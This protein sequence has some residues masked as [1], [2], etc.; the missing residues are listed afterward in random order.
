MPGGGRHP[1]KKS[2]AASSG[3]T[4]VHAA[5]EPNVVYRRPSALRRVLLKDDASLPSA[6]LDATQQLA[7]SLL[8]AKPVVWRGTGDLWQMPGL[9]SQAFRGR[10]LLI[11]FWAGV[12]GL[13][14]ALLSLGINFIGVSAEPSSD[15]VACSKKCM[16]NLVHV[17]RV[18]QL[19]PSMFRSLLNSKTFE[20]VILG[21]GSPCQG[22]S[23]LN[24]GRLGLQDPRSCQPKIL[25]DFADKMETDLG[26]EV[27][28][29]LE[30]AGSVPDKVAKQYS[31]W[32]RCP[33]LMSQ[34]GR[35]GWVTRKRKYWLRGPSGDLFSKLVKLPDAWEILEDLDD[36][37]E[38]A[39]CGSKPLPP[40]V[41]FTGGYAPLFDPCE[42][43]K[44]KGKGA[45][46]PF[47]REFRHPGDNKQGVSP[48]ACGRYE[49]D[50]RRF[51][52]ASYELESLLWYGN[53]WRQPDPT[54][55][56]IIHGLPPSIVSAISSSNSAK[57]IQTQNSLVGNGFHMPTVVV[58]IFC[59]LQLG[60]S[61]CPVPL[62]DTSEQALKG[63]LEGTVWYPGRMHTFP[64]LKSA[65]HIVC[66]MRLQLQPTDIPESVWVRTQIELAKCELPEL[67]RFQAFMVS[68]GC[69][70]SF[71]GPAVMDA[72]KRAQIFAGLSGQRHTG[73]SKRGLD[74]LLPPGL[75]PVQHMAASASLPSPFLPTHWP[76]DDVVFV[77]TEWAVWQEYL[78]LYALSQ[79]SH[80]QRAAAALSELSSALN[81]VKCASA[82][83]VALAKEPAFVA[84]LTALLCWPDTSQ[85]VAFVSGFGIVGEFQHTGVFRPINLDK[86]EADISRE[87]WLQDAP[88][89]IENVMNQGPPR[90]PDLIYQL[91]M[92]E[93]KK[94]FCSS[95]LTKQEVDDLFGR[96]KWRPLERFLVIDPSGKPRVIDNARKTEHNRATLMRETIHTTNVD[97]VPSCIRMVVA[98]S[99][100]RLGY[101]SL[102]SL[103]QSDIMTLLPWL[104]PRIATDDLPDAYR[105]HP[106]RDDHL[107]FSIVVVWT[108][109]GWMFVVMYGLAFGLESAVVNFNRFPMLGVAAARRCVSSICAA[110]FDDEL[111]VDLLL[112]A[113]VSKPG[114]I[115]IFQLMGSPPQAS[116][117]FATAANRTYLGASLHVGSVP[118]DLCV[119]VQPKTTTTIKVAA[120]INQT[121]ESGVLQSDDAGKLRGDAQWLFS[122]TAGRIGKIASPLLTEAGKFQTTT[123][124]LKPRDRET[125]QFLLRAVKLPRPRMIP[126]FGSATHLVRIY[127]DASFENQSLRLGWVIFDPRLPKPI[128]RTALVSPQV[129]QRWIPRKQQIY[130]GE[131]VCALVIPIFHEQLLSD[132]DIIHFID[133]EAAAASLIRGTSTQED[134]HEIVLSSSLLYH[135]MGSRVWYEWVD[136]KANPSD[137][138]SRN[139][140]RDPW[141]VAQDWDLCEVSLPHTLCTRDS[142]VA[143]W[144]SFLLRSG[145]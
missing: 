24:P 128:G 122:M 95:F 131:A 100:Q 11:E 38:L 2:T 76:E 58:L 116:K 62:C 41:Q 21:G 104:A 68:R 27:Y 65:E 23:S 63:R 107:P 98:E 59:L 43:V 99:L 18:E 61:C 35:C 37:M 53:Q 124:A 75:D 78:P 142:L 6:P 77:T 42:I 40:R 102:D 3:T 5:D 71:L 72:R 14:L 125:L 139:G 109:W 101:T 126:L 22:N 56:C 140:V 13:A 103:R 84:F 52:P 51:P 36:S 106:V 91:T 73:D 39:Y 96:G 127:S 26:V 144:D 120:R 133:N 47:T 90:H 46:F 114:L 110:Y 64:G 105:G 111:S 57:R 83:K 50:N 115:M 45:M 7:Q 25:A 30:N 94:G 70:N 66:D 129:L 141:T 117:G 82:K 118:L 1:T 93:Q 123:Y 121:L 4:A 31:D 16:P 85:A 113:S 135:N 12:S 86:A 54:E 79:R 33:Y 130:P 19:D 88:S 49:E 132:S 92:E 60:A 97:F 137:G 87:E 134:V 28:I 15:A 67:Q 89:R 143:V 136:T 17:D 112:H 9:D 48:E 34:S 20:G 80:I 44:K 74:H 69:A 108:P 32:L 81:T 8:A 138:L 119:Q 55:R 10:W 145:S 29:F